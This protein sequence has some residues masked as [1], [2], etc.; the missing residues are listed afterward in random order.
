MSNLIQDAR[1][2]VRLLLKNPGFSLT[3]ILV[4][5]LGIGANAAVFTLVNDAD[6]PAAGRQPS[7]RARWSA[8]TATTTRAPTRTAASRIPPTST[9]ATERDSF[10][11][12]TAFTLAFVGVGEGDATRRT[13]AVDRQRATTSRRSAST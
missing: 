6:V 11:H 3:A 8:S 12:V 7:G 4:L 9:S 2:S 10:S 13:F 1:H 5:A